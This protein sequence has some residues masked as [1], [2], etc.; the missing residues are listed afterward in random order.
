ME[1]ASEIQPLALETPCAAIDGANRLTLTGLPPE[2]L[3]I[4]FDFL[5]AR[6]NADKAFLE[7]DRPWL[8]KSKR[9]LSG[10]H[11]LDAISATS[12]GLRAQVND[13][14]L[15]FLLKYKHMAPM[16][17]PKAG[18]KHKTFN[19]LRSRTNGLLNWADHHCIFCGKKTA[20]FAIMM[21]G[22]RCCGVCDYKEW[23]SKIT[24]VS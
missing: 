7:L 19:A 2:L 15:H 4:V 20:R 12:K 5:F 9:H 6:H 17:L 13:W 16:R 21:N 10:L 1:M 14:A 18:Q 24:K 22:F 11:P 23:P 3:H 8:S